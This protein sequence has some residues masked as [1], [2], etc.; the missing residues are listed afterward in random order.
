MRKSARWLVRGFL[1]VSLGFGFL[2]FKCR[3]AVALQVMAETGSGVNGGLA[4]PHE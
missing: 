3:G 4:Q 2:A 1:L